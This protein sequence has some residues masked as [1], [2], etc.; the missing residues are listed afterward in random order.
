MQREEFLLAWELLCHLGNS[1]NQEKLFL[2]L[3]NVNYSY[4]YFKAFVLLQGAL[5][6]G[7]CRGPGAFCKSIPQGFGIQAAA[8]TNWLA[9]CGVN[10]NW[11]KPWAGLCCSELY[12]ADQG[13]PGGLDEPGAGPGLTLIEV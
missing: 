10:G 9:Q 4:S 6:L 3:W 1:V 2:F 11:D 7:L 8:N 13:G 5:G 12:G